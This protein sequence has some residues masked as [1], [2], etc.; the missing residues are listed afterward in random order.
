MDSQD[1]V[2]YQRY[3]LP[4]NPKNDHVGVAQVP[5]NGEHRGSGFDAVAALS[6]HKPINDPTRPGP[7]FPL[8]LVAAL[9]S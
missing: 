5:A 7:A 3:P 1:D 4:N 2:G 6:G 8:G 9:N